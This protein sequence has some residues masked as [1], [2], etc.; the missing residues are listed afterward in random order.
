MTQHAVEAM[1][2]LELPSV[3]RRR[4][5]SAELAGLA[6]L[7]AIALL[8]IPFGSFGFFVGHYALIYSILGLSAVVVTG[9]AGLVSLMPYSFPGICAMVTGVAMA[10]WGWP[11][12]HALPLAPPATTH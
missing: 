8:P 11:F 6:G 9:Y 5:T 4:L 7:G 1:K 12:W 2:P 3:V 10:S